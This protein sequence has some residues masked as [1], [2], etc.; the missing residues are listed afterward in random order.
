[1]VRFEMKTEPNQTKLFA[2]FKIIKL[3]CLY[4]ELNR[5]VSNRTELLLLIQLNYFLKNKRNRIY[6]PN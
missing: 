2:K 5:I 6:L 4:F 3:N 1:M